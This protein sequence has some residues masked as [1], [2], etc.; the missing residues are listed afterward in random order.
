M[1]LSFG[2]IFAVAFVLAL[3]GAMMPGPLLTVTIAQTARRGFIASV[4][5]VLGHAIL[6]LL[7]VGGL[8]LG[9]GNVLRTHNAMLFVAIVGGSMLLW[10]GWGM[11]REG[12]AGREAAGDPSREADLSAVETKSNARLVACGIGVS[13]SNPYW[14][15]WWAT[16]G[17]SGLTFARELTGSVVMAVGGFFLGHILGDILWYLSV[18]LAVVTGRRLLSPVVY[19]RIISVC[20]AFLLFLGGSFLYMVASGGISR[21]NFGIQSISF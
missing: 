9:L 3:S 15:L 4:L 14:V 12:L 2:R 11:I 5:I 8:I 1:N 7:L 17:I 10:M 20:G 6:E 13:L 19:R 16:V 21:M 18:G